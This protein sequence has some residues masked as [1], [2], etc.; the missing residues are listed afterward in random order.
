MSFSRRF[1]APSRRLG[2]LAATAC[3][4]LA[5]PA[6]S[7]CG[8]GEETT[9]STTGLGDLTLPELT[10]SLEAEAAEFLERPDSALGVSLHEFLGPRIVTEVERGSAIC[11]RG[12]DTPSIDD[13]QRYP[14]ACVVRGSADGQG[15]LVEITL[16]FVGTGVEGRCWHAVNERV[17]VTTTRPATLSKPEALKPPNRLEACAS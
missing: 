4:V 5:L 7:G 13:P 12:R 6:L 16:G 17:L 15:L 10:A 1:G 11:R 14:F 9:V 3:L 2:A 8:G